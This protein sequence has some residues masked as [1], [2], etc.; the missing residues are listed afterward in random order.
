VEPII[1]IKDYNYVVY[2]FLVRVNLDSFNFESISAMYR[3]SG[4]YD[5][6]GVVGTISF[7]LLCVEKFNMKNRWNVVLLISGLISMSLF[8]YIAFPV[9][10]VFIMV[11]SRSIKLW[12]KVLVLIAFLGFAAFSYSNEILNTLIWSRIE[13]RGSAGEIL[14]SRSTDELRNYVDQIAFSSDYFFGVDDRSL[15]ERFS[16][17]SSIYNVIIGYG[18]ISIIL[19]SI[20]FIIYSLK[21]STTTKSAF[22]CIAVIALTLVQRPGLFILYY[23]FL[24]RCMIEVPSIEERLTPINQT[25]E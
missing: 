1:A 11:T 16:S 19:Y 6:P 5:E 10:L 15:I 7:L 2:P 23:L 22:V 4:L 13:G 8:F 18:M 20:F 25:Y 12:R 21:F 3:F 14:D 9:Y 17:S 24:F